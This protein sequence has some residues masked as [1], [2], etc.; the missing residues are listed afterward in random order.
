MRV[1]A[2]VVAVALASAVVGGTA[3]VGTA[4]GSAVRILLGVALIGAGL[5]GLELHAVRGPRVPPVPRPRTPTRWCRRDDRHDDRPVARPGRPPARARPLAGLRR[6]RPGL[7]RRRG[8]ARD[9]PADPCRGPADRDGQP[10]VAPVGDGAAPLRRRQHGASLLARRRHGR[11]ARTVRPTDGARPRPARHPGRLSPSDR[12]A[13]GHV[14]RA[15]PRH[16]RDPARVEPARGVAPRAV[17]RQ[18]HRARHLGARHRQ[19]TTALVVPLPRLAR[20][21][22]RPRRDVRGRALGQLP[23]DRVRARRR[24]PVHAPRVLAGG[25]DGRVRQSLRGRP[26]SD[27]RQRRRP[28][29]RP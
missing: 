9:L 18:R 25:D 26:R 10:R 1:V 23:R 13:L 19:R 8:R 28:R 15:H 16:H 17:R 22:R 2:I 21:P 29:R 12:L 3:L 24:L 20:P 5:T 4:D 7:D 27:H 6:R 14:P 11:R